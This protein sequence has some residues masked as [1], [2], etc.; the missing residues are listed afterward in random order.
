MLSNACTHWVSQRVHWPSGK[1]RTRR[2]EANRNSTSGKASERQQ[3]EF[4]RV[5]DSVSV[6]FKW[7]DDL[8][9]NIYHVSYYLNLFAFQTVW[10]C[11]KNTKRLSSVNYY[12]MIY[13]VRIVWLACIRI[14]HLFH[15]LNEGRFIFTVLAEIRAC[16]PCPSLPAPNFYKHTPYR[17]YLQLS[18][19]FTKPE[20]CRVY[21]RSLCW[22]AH[23]LHDYVFYHVLKPLLF[24]FYEHHVLH[25]PSPCVAKRLIPGKKKK[26][27]MM[28]DFL[29]N[30]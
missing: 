13:L 1:T 8:S 22:K 16:P 10:H 7:S 18:S 9:Y 2:S 20:G 24:I 21:C 4:Q 17:R 3:T 30:S 6:Y 28:K 23:I 26:N 11:Q 12:V 25:E 27:E 15:L 5:W 29:E 14:I 19:C